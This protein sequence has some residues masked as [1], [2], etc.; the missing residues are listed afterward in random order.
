MLVTTFAATGAVMGV[1]AAHAADTSF[2]LPADQHYLADCGRFW[3]STGY[4]QT[5]HI[6][7]DNYVATLDFKMTQSQINSLECVSPYL[8]LDFHIFGFSTPS[9][10]DRYSVSTNIPG[11]IHDVATMDYA[12]N[13]AT[14]G[15]TRIRAADL[16]AGTEY[17]AD[18]IFN[19]PLVPA[20]G[21]P[22]VSIEWVPSYWASSVAEQGFCAL[23]RQS[24]GDA[25]CVFGK[26]RVYL[27]HAYNNNVSLIFDGYRWWEFSSATPTSS[28]P[29]STDI[30]PSPAPAPSSNPFGSLDEAGSVAD[31]AKVRVRGWAIDPDT[32][33]SITVHIYIDGAYAGATTANMSRPDIGAAYPGYGNNHGYEAQYAIGSGAHEVCA[34]AINTGSGSV[35]TQLP[36][37]KPVQGPQPPRVAS[38]DSSHTLWI[39][40]GAIGAVWTQVATGVDQ[41][42][43]SLNRIA[44]LQGSTLA[45]KEG[46]MNAPWVTVGTNVSAFRVTD[47]R[48]GALFGNDLSI[49]EGPLGAGWTTVSTNVIDFDMSPKRIAVLDGD[50]YLSVKEGAIGASW[51]MV[52]GGADGFSVSDTRVD[53]WGGGS[54]YVKDGSIGATWTL[55][56]ANSIAGALSQ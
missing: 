16:Q 1:S 9:E 17:H 12:L 15:L 31:Q 42:G 35:N 38:L 45:I 40:E 52:S 34:Y 5:T 18:V 43:L 32:T 36:S 41:F 4:F 14:P 2:L 27:S 53:V 49:K 55:V 51:T 3:P 56:S 29:P 46:A 50:G 30:A 8:E 7:G 20:N 37:C 26:T 13:D 47:N 11:A 22:R 44:I 25:E 39:K 6:S 48:V 33:S 24:M 23:W 21:S 54:L 10:W 28:T 19:Q